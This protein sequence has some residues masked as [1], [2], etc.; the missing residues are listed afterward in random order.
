MARW[1]MPDMLRMSSASMEASRSIKDS[2]FGAASLASF[3]RCAQAQKASTSARTRC[4]R[5]ASGSCR[6]LLLRPVDVLETTELVELRRKLPVRCAQRVTA[7]GSWPISGSSG[8]SPKSFLVSA[9]LNGDSSIGADGSTGVLTTSTWAFSC[10]SSSSSSILSSFS[11]SHSELLDDKSS[12]FSK[13][14]G[15][16]PSS[17]SDRCFSKVLM[18]G[19]KNPSGCLLLTDMARTTPVLLTLHEIQGLEHRS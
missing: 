2:P 14:L 6:T 18:S 8:R 12:D 10:W 9:K 15:S 3:W 1:T 5:R 7:S 19:A 13:L 16:S 17:H 11:P 4:K